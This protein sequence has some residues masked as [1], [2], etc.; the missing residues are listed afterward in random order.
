MIVNGGTAGA[1]GLFGVGREE[2][3][4]ARLYLAGSQLSAVDLIRLEPFSGDGQAE[5]ITFSADETCQKVDD[6]CY[7]YQQRPQQ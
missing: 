6:H 2:V 3:G 7:Y 1:G 5:R 4:F